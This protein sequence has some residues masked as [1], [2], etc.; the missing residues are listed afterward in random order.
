ME[1]PVKAYVKLELRVIV[2]FLALKGEMAD[3]INA[4]AYRSILNDLRAA[5]WRKCPGRPRD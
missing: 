1:L 2:Q 4:A 3:T 5:I